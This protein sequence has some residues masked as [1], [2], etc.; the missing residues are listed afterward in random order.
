M[1]GWVSGD[2]HCRDEWSFRELLAEV[3]QVV[4]HGLEPAATRL[5]I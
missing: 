1:E 4:A 5:R 2:G 3:L